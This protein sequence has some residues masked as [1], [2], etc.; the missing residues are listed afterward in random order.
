MWFAHYLQISIRLL[1]V[2]KAVT[3]F[4]GSIGSLHTSGTNFSHETSCLSAALFLPCVWADFWNHVHAILHLGTLG[5]RSLIMRKLHYLWFYDGHT[6]EKHTFP[7]FGSPHQANLLHWCYHLMGRQRFR[8]K[9]SPGVQ[10]R[11]QTT[12]YYTSTS[13]QGLI[14]LIQDIYFFHICLFSAV[15]SWDVQQLQHRFQEPLL[16]PHPGNGIA[17]GDN[18]P[19]GLEVNGSKAMGWSPFI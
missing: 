11:I 3:W 1:F 8:T 18:P 6:Q 12:N 13:I 10:N 4:S 7:S 9:C 5:S 2:V 19:V 16:L 15:S 17:A 14:C